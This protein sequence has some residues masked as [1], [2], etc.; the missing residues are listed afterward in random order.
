MVDF[1]V[2]SVGVSP[3]L[4][5]KGAQE[6]KTAA[7]EK[8]S[9]G[10]WLNKSINTVNRMQ[11]EADASAVKLTTGESKDIHNT[12]IDMQKADIAMNLLMEVRNKVI[13]AYEE[14]KR[15]QI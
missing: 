15:M 4:S 7:L 8:N 12:M 1:N 9:F 3:L 10:D 13:S 14:V 6:S 2:Q 5:Q 11:Q